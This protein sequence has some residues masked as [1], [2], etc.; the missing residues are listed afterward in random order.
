LWNGANLPA[1]S[2]AVEEF[3]AVTEHKSVFRTSL[4]EEATGTIHN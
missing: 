2:I 4:L 1:H 3:F